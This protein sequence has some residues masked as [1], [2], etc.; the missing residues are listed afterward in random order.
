MPKHRTYKNIGWPLALLGTALVIAAGCP[1]TSTESPSADTTEQRNVGAGAAQ[2]VEPA[3]PEF[4]GQVVIEIETP[5]G[6][7]DEGTPQ[8]DVANAAD[9]KKTEQDFIDDNG[10]IFEDWPKPKLALIVSASQQGYIEPCGC[11]G[12]ENMKGGMSRRH[13]LFEKL[14]GDGW[15]LLPI[16][17]GDLVRRIGVQPEIK[18][19]RMVDALRLMKYQ[20]VGIGAKDLRLPAATL[21]A[22]LGGDSDLPLVSANV[23][24]FTIDSGF[25]QDHRIVEMGGMKIGITTALAPSEGEALQNPEID[26]RPATEVLPAIVEKL[27][28]AGCDKTVLLVS[29]SVEEATEMVEQIAGF[30]YV[31][32]TGKRDI[33]PDAPQPIEGSETQ[34][35]EM[36]KK[37]MYLGV[38]GFFDDDDQ[39][40][41]YQRVP[42]DGRFENSDRVREILVSYQEQLKEQGW[43]GLAIRPT[44]HQSGH[45]YVGSESCGEC[46]TE[47]FSVWE[48]TP[49]AHA[50]ETLAKLEPSRQ[51]DPECI[52]CHATGWQPQRYVPFKS[53]YE[54]E[55]DTP[56]LVAQGC[57]NCHGPGANHVAAEQGEVELEMAEKLSLR[58]AMRTTKEQAEEWRCAECHDLDN[59]PG[60]D[61]EKAWPE[62]EHWGKD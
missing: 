30:D 32:A 29:G 62:I 1:G 4:E 37:G 42:L 6:D 19:Q 38:L 10:A 9:A 36:T 12:L 13:T 53:G 17:A 5:V 16:D 20:A 45:S 33:P 50:T 7:R 31:I 18:Y 40:V 15:L 61:F 35:L 11:A 49:H 39:P 28:A 47:A 2:P 57:E 14:T 51:F 26:Y 56:H 55:V 46:H 48:K 22:T 59:S 8:V 58:E 34:L 27:Q 23:G 3:S 24:L 41:R 52:S 54:S 25:T 21:V 43:E 44:P 60:F